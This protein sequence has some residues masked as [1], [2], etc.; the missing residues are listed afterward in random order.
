VLSLSAI[1]ADMG[2]ITAGRIRNPGNT[3]GINVSGTVPGTWVTYMDLT[4]TGSTPWLKHGMLDLY[5]DGTGSLG[6][7]FLILSYI[8]F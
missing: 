2:E 4:A 1:S 7:L 3:V 8:G 5:Q 6:D